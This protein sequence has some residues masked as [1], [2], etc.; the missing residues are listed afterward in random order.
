MKQT[1]IFLLLIALLAPSSEAQRRRS[2]S[3]EPSVELSFSGAFGASREVINRD[4]GGFDDQWE[5]SED[6]AVLSIRPAFFFV[7]WLAFEP[8]MLWTAGSGRPPAYSLSANFAVNIPI[9]RSPV[10]PFAIIGYGVGN[11]VP[12]VQRV[13][14]RGDSEPWNVRLTNAGAGVKFF[15]TPAAFMRV[16]YRFC[17]VTN[18]RKHGFDEGPYSEKRAYYFNDF[19]LGVGIAL[20]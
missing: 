16:E 6:Y 20:Y 12:R 18:E 17:M 8:E 13:Y 15:A 11:A 7:P 4:Y 1:A 10:I 3:I 9:P 14:E 19:L 2:A 5:S